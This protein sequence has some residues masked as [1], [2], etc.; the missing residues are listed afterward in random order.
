VKNQT[1]VSEFE[2][3]VLIKN[4]L[5]EISDSALRTKTKKSF[6]QLNLQFF[7]LFSVVIMNIIK[8]LELKTLSPQDATTIT[9]R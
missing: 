9:A 8:K 6:F 7:W 3:K 2:H 4:D 1:S 5:I